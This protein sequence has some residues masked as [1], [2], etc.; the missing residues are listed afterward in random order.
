MRF[1]RADA[2]EH[3]FEHWRVPPADALAVSR[4]QIFL[5]NRRCS[6]AVFSAIYVLAML[7][8]LNKFCGP[9][10]EVAPTISHLR[11]RAAERLQQRLRFGDLLQDLLVP[12]EFLQGREGDLFHRVDCRFKVPGQAAL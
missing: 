6:N 3:G 12:F 1:E 11:K 7:P 5:H 8:V 10:Y 2:V 4:R 9:T